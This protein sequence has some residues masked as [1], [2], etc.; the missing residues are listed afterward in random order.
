MNVLPLAHRLTILYLAL[1]VA[2]WLVSWLEWW[3]G[4]PAVLAMTLALRDVLR[5]PW[6]ASPTRRDLV[7]ALIALGWVLSLPAGGLLAGESGDMLTHRAI[8]LD[9]GRGSWPTYVTDHLRDEP[10]LL[11]YYL[12][13]YL[14]PGLLGRWFGAAAL[15]W[16]VPLWTW[17]GLALLLRLFTRNMATT[18]GAGAAAFALV[19]FSGMDTV[20]FLLRHALF[21]LG[22]LSSER[23]LFWGY[24]WAYP[25]DRPDSYAKIDYQSHAMILGHSPQHFLTGGLGALLLFQLR[26]HA[27]FLAASGVVIAACVF[28]S[29][30]TSVGLAALAIALFAENG[31]RPFLKWQ[32]LVPAPFVGGL[33][34]LYLTSGGSADLGSRWLTSLYENGHRL[35]FD[36]GLAY[37]CEFLLLALLL[38]RMRPDIVRDPFFV[39]SL[40]TLLLLPWW[41]LGDEPGLNELLL[42]PPI[43]PLLLLCHYAAHALAKHW[44]R[45]ATTSRPVAAWA[46]VAVLA[47]GAHSGI[48]WHLG[49]TTEPRAAPYK[50]SARSLL[51]DLQFLYIKQ[52]TGPPPSGLL[53]VVL[54]DHERKG[55]PLGEVLFQ[56]KLQPL[57][58]VFFWEKRLLYAT[59][60]VCD[61]NEG[62]RFLLRFDASEQADDSA[63][64]EIHDFGKLTIK[65]RKGYGDC[66]IRRELPAHPFTRVTTGRIVD[67]RLIWMANIPFANRRPAPVETEADGKGRYKAVF[68]NTARRAEA[69]YAALVA[70]RPAAR[71][72]WDVFLSGDT[73]TYVKQPCVAEETRARFFLHAVPLEDS[74][75]PSGRRSSGFAN[76][77]FGFEASGVVFNGKCMVQRELPGYALRSLATGQLAPDGTR[78]WHA[79]IDVTSMR[80]TRQT[81]R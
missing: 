14:V 31:V 65:N 30:L 78:A 27:R 58:T 49:Y 1:P 33:V 11:R 71:A 28:W 61:R 64:Y 63:A 4:V 2:I 38:W 57:D 55:G 59:R 77:D 12:G 10:P 44:R 6:R 46:L 22:E 67:G 74:D 23:F 76:L 25:A 43:A 50:E 18:R 47:A 24:E 16:A 53:N 79:E 54:R 75:L 72:E 51:V 26:R 13:Y 48:A 52:K 7:L 17:I 5:G 45:D 70:G 37:C 19:F 36:L 62:I 66:I 34:V 8:F 9:L 60:R 35:G 40:A 73:A 3:V 56:S 80:T 69:Q 20:S 15:N 81:S 32:N 68:D 42:R 41:V 29:P 21:G 39:A